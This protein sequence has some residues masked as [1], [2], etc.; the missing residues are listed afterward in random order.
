MVRTV[1]HFC[2][3]IMTHEYT[4]LECNYITSVR[5][6]L[7]GAAGVQVAHVTVKDIGVQCSLPVGPKLPI[8]FFPTMFKPYSV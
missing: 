6:F 1:T 5:T 2:L 4:S 8:S 7:H 3:L